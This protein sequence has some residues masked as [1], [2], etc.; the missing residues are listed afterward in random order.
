MLTILIGKHWCFIW[1]T[2]LYFLKKEWGFSHAPINIHTFSLGQNLQISISLKKY[3]YFD[4]FNLKIFHIIWAHQKCESS[5]LYCFNF[6]LAIWGL[7]SIHVNLMITS[8]MY[9]KRCWNLIEIAL[10]K[11][12][13]RQ[14]WNLNHLSSDPWTQD[15]ILFI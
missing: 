13:F 12:S 7:L 15:V 1:G 6:S 4:F 10:N 14:Y 11:Y 8:S 3:S 2:K 9:V 5:D